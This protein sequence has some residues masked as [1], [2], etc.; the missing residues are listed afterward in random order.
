MSLKF[1]L[2]LAASVMASGLTGCA[3]SSQ[4]KAPV[5]AVGTTNTSQLSDYMSRVTVGMSDPE[6]RAALGDPSR[7]RAN[8]GGGQIWTYEFDG[9]D[10]QGVDTR[11]ASQV[12]TGAGIFLPGDAGRAMRGVGTIGSAI[13]GR[14]ARQQTQ[15]RLQVVV[16]FVNDHVADVTGEAFN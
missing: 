4:A 3:S 9:A 10:N 2:I 15:R 12:L 8:S 7:V 6:V 11:T 14:T 16:T 13:G 1:S 5:P